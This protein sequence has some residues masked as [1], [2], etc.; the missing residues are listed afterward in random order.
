MYNENYMTPVP[1]SCYVWNNEHVTSNL[2]K[3]A[4]SGYNNMPYGVATVER[5]LELAK[6]ICCYLDNENNIDF[7]EPIWLKDADQKALIFLSASG[8]YYRI[9]VQE[10]IL[11]M[12]DHDFQIRYMEC[13]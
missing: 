5:K 7:N 11:W 13:A 9:L 1:G 6:E 12:H 2:R 10:K 4:T 8:S 3:I